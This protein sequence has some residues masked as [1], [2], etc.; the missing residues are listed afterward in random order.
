M[1]SHSFSRI[2]S[3]LQIPE[4]RSSDKYESL[5]REMEMEGI[6]KKNDDRRYLAAKVSVCLIPCTVA[7]HGVEM[8][9][10]PSDAALSEFRRKNV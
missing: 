7:G 6:C 3:L 4:S 5:G 1:H 9:T 10:Q 2:D 8:R